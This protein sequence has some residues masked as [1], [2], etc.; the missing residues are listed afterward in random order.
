V[1]RDQDEARGAVERGEALSLVDVLG[2]VRSELGGEVIGVSFK[3][4]RWPLDL[5]VQGYWCPRQLSEVYVDAT[6]GQIL[7]R[8]EH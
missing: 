1:D 5:R 3:T 2:R 7:K 6:A 8:E 4:S